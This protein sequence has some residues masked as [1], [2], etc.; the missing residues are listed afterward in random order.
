MDATTL[1]L[2]IVVEWVSSLHRQA[3]LF[4]PLF[5]IRRSPPSPAA[6]FLRPQAGR[7][8]QKM[9]EPQS[10][11][12]HF[13]ENTQALRKRCSASQPPLVHRQVLPVSC[14]TLAVQLSERQCASLAQ[15]VHV[16]DAIANHDLSLL[17]ASHTAYVST[18]LDFLEPGTGRNIIRAFLRDHDMYRSPGCP[19][20]VAFPCACTSQ[21]RA[22]ILHSQTHVRAQ[23][24]FYCALWRASRSGGWKERRINHAADMPARP[25][26]AIPHDTI[27]ESLVWQRMKKSRLGRN[28]I[29]DRGM[30]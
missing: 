10:L 18:C 20:R 27:V 4:R 12:H 7:P 16:L 11:I 24:Y 19:C 6:A 13:Q 25:Q 21:D 30:H 15:S 26:G 2:G 5:I 29:K 23:G 22:V 9:D 3:F 17:E 14:T 28:C 1:A 8:N